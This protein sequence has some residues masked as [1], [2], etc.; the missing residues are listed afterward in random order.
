MA[1]ALI[2]ITIMLT[3]LTACSIANKDASLAVKYTIEKTLN[4]PSVWNG[5]FIVKSERGGTL[6]HVNYDGEHNNDGEYILS[7][8]TQGMAFSSRAKVKKEGGKLYVM[9]QNAKDW[10]ETT[11]NDL[12]MLGLGFGNSPIEFAKSLQELDIVIQT[13]ERKNVYKIIVKDGDALPG[14][15]KVSN[16]TGVDELIPVDTP[17]VYVEVNPEDETMRSLS[18]YVEYTDGSTLFY[19]VE[20][21]KDERSNKIAENSD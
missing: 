18:M 19:E 15:E 11:P 5:S 7:I 4:Q 3:F 13:T 21:E 10:Q 12:K 1:R 8:D 16:V 9:L 20:I 14:T 2:F 17:E 6:I